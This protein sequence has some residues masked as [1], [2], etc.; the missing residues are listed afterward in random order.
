MA[1]NL[2]SNEGIL[3]NEV[4]I[5]VLK[6]LK[7]AGGFEEIFRLRKICKK[8]NQLVLAVVQDEFLKELFENWEFVLNIANINSYR[9]LT[10]YI[11]KNLSYDQEE[12]KSLRID[13]SEDENLC[14]KGNCKTLHLY[15]EFRKSSFRT[16]SYDH[17]CYYEL[18]FNKD[19]KCCKCKNSSIYL[20]RIAGEHFCI[21]NVKINVMKL[22]GLERY[23]Y[24]G[25]V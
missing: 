20:K 17:W 24:F 4:I 23:F 7:M 8:W 6:N 3:P 22:I 25:H 19:I 16:M 12:Y 2:Q 13:F 5:Y 18:E 21:E 1:S 10:K 11:P 9:E 14:L 15:P